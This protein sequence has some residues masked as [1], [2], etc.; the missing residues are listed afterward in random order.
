LGLCWALAG[1]ATPSE[2]GSISVTNLVTDD[3][4]VNPAQ[5]TDTFLKNAWGISHSAGSPFWV[6]DNGTGVTT[7]YSV[8]PNTNA[9][10]KVILGSPP[11]PSGGVVI[12][13]PGSGTP[14]GQVFNTANATAFNKDL[15]LFVSEDGTISGWRGA[16]GTTA[17]VLQ[18][19]L[20]ANVYKGTTL[21]TTGGHSYLL[22]ANFRAGTIDV[23]KG[24][25]GAPDLAGRF[26][27]PNTPSGY[28]P[29]NVQTLGDKIYVTYA[30]Q[31]SAK[32]DDDPGAGH[33]FVTAFDQQGVFLGRIGSMGTLNSP[34]GL[35]IA[36]SSF[37][38]FAGDLLVGNFGDGMINVFN[39]NPATPGFLGQLT[40][41]DGK[42]I[43]IDGLWGLIPGNDGSGGSSQ[44]IYFSAG[45][46]GEANGLFGVLQS[47]QSTPEPSSMVLGLTAAGLL[48]GRWIWKNRRRPVTA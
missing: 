13:P 19:G 17:E 2:G 44:N 7:L 8:N 16:L 1:F 36:P 48:A 43:V 42:P 31:D 26:T 47:A 27:D 18:T 6:S 40:G 11:D 10:T 37:G 4:S 29:F 9:T 22:S 41:A 39:P 5:L 14:T 23:L 46:N 33:G 28:A 25:T 15:F 21:D 38:D 20:T 34:W 35:A 45:P 24:D 30:L 3:Q 12:P 32:H